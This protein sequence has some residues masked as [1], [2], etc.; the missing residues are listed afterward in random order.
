[1]FTCQVQ[2]GGRCPPQSDNTSE[3]REYDVVVLYSRGMGGSF[4]LPPVAF[5]DGMLCAKRA[6]ASFMVSIELLCF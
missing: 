1:M 5:T 3:Q 6:S 4:D 2:N